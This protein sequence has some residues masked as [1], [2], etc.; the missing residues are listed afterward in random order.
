MIIEIKNVLLNQQIQYNDLNFRKTFLFDSK[1]IQIHEIKFI[2]F[3][4]KKLIQNVV[5]ID[6]NS[7]F[8][9]FWYEFWTYVDR[10]R[11]SILKSL[12][13]FIDDKMSINVLILFENMS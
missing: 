13:V 8:I 11:R 5:C 4:M 3:R 1:I 12:N 10:D 7:Y 2:V 9:S 6:Q